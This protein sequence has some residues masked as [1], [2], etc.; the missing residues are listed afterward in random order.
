MLNKAF[1]TTN[2]DVLIH[3][4]T[5]IR[6]IKYQLIKEQLSSPVRVYRAQLIS[7]EE[8]AILQR[9][10]GE[11]ISINSFFSSSIDRAYIVFLLDSGASDGLERVLFEID[12]DPHVMNTKPFADISSYSFFPTETEVLFMA[13]CM[14]RLVSL[15]QENGINVVH[16][17]ICSD[18]DNC[19]K[20]LFKHAR[21]EIGEM[22]NLCTL[23]FL[24]FKSGKFEAAKKCLLQYLKELPEHHTDEAQCLLRLGNVLHELGEYDES[25]HMYNKALKINERTLAATDPII[26]NNYN[27]LGIVYMSQGDMKQALSSYE[28]AFDIY[29]RAYGEDHERITISLDNIGSVYREEKKYDKALEYFRKSLAIKEHLFPADHPRSAASHG[30]IADVA[31]DTGHLDLAM[32]HFQLQL[33]ML[34]KSLPHDHL[35]IA[36]CY[37]S[38]AIILQRQGDFMEALRMFEKANSINIKSLPPSHPRM[39]DVKKLLQHIQAVKTIM[40]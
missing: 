8:I 28:K 27:N 16:L 33:K 14:F 24:L 1:R 9:S 35:D 22:N 31:F 10:V 25:L 7:S 18:D 30:Y 6:D 3:F 13:G 20:K 2:I 12:A 21:E 4:R 34:L 19:L 29:K 40:N 17:T 11:I 26:G 15:R 36:D 32:E 39:I 23:G 38:I 5:V 37:T